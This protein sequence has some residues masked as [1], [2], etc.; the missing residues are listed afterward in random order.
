MLQPSLAC[1]CY[2]S[3]IASVAS[4]GGNSV[5]A[6]VTMTSGGLPRFHI[7]LPSRDETCIFTLR[8]ISNTVGD[9]VKAIEDEDKG[10]DRVAFLGTGQL[11]H[12]SM[13]L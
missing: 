7:P 3:A 12:K 10:I 11:C 8:P 2:A 1:R 6:S 13:Y 5:G 9:L 4:S